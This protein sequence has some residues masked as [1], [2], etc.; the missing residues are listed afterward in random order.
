MYYCRMKKILLILMITPI[1]FISYNL[2][3]SFPVELNDCDI[4]IL[5]SG[6]EISVKVIEITPDLIKYKYCD[7]ENSPLISVN[8]KQRYSIK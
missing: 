3:A 5:E 2:F 8:V 1:L 4:I 7:K 6:D